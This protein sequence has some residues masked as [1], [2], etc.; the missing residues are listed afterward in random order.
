M[1]T[2]TITMPIVSEGELCLLLLFNVRDV[3]RPVLES[4]LTKGRYKIRVRPVFIN[5]FTRLKGKNTGRSIDA[6]TSRG[7]FIYKGVI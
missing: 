2:E 6:T 3:I 7:T 4:A 5:P 1:H